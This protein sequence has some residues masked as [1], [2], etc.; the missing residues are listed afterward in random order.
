MPPGSFDP[1][2]VPSREAN[3]VP[4]RHAVRQGP[5]G[6]EGQYAADEVGAQTFDRRDLRVD[7][8][9]L[10][11]QSDPGAIRHRAA[12]GH[13]DLRRIEDGRFDLK[14]RQCAHGELRVGIHPAPRRR[15]SIL[16]CRVGASLPCL[17]GPAQGC[18]STDCHNPRPGPGFGPS[19]S[20]PCEAPVCPGGRRA[21]RTRRRSRQFAREPSDL[22]SSPAPQGR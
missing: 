9:S 20:P 15:R 10:R 2:H 21:A 13:G 8:D 22:A 11:D 17:R 14:F 12:L 19:S 16:P 6:R 18:R 5:Q 3:I 4:S 1:V 7:L